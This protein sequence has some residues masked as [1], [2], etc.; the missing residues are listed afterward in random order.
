MRRCKSVAAGILCLL[1]LGAFC[2]S[3]LAVSDDWYSFL[4]DVLSEGDMNTWIRETLP[5]S[6]GEG[7]E[8]YVLALTQ[9]DTEYDFSEYAVSLTAY[10][11]KETIPSAVERQRI[12]LTLLAL[13]AESDIPRQVASESIGEQGVMS[14]VFGL[15]LVQNGAEDAKYSAEEIVSEILARQLPDGGWAVSGEYAD[16]DVTAMVL[17]ALA[18]QRDSCEEAIEKGIAL[19]SE[20]QLPNGGYKSYGVEASESISQVII[21]LTALGIDPKTDG[22]FLKN[23]CSM[24]D[25]WKQFRLSDGSFSH[26]AGGQ[27]NGYACQQALL[28]LTALSRFESGKEGLYLFEPGKLVQSPEVSAEGA[29]SEETQ[30]L[31]APSA[32]EVSSSD[33]F[34]P[35]PR[36]IALIVA[37]S[38]A[39]GSLLYLLFAKKKEN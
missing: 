6:A 28:A 8:W 1:L 11:S 21:A 13:G 33:G 4:L 34:L 20:K 27:K 12:A 14:W 37:V 2:I 39:A 3:A 24:L 23:G 31:A 38:V 25:A 36:L 9:S 30:S 10:F 32:D 17:Q 29:A 22:R 19:L 35:L 26:T 15:H 18:G 16:V 7:A 5:A